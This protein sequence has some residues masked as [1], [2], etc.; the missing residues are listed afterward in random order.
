MRGGGGRVSRR[1]D[2]SD[3]ESALREAIM[4]AEAAFL[5]RA[6]EVLALPPPAGFLVSSIRAALHTVHR[7]R[8]ITTTSQP[9]IKYTPPPVDH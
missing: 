9:R 2:G 1:C 6:K 4:G 3:P 7:T 8:K 5:A